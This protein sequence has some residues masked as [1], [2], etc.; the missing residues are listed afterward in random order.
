MAPDFASERAKNPMRL[1]ITLC[2]GAKI[3]QIKDQFFFFIPSK[4]F[5]FQIEEQRMEE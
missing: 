1:F 5:I 4:K 3:T 2:N